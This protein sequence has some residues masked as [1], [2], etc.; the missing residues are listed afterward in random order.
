MGLER[1]SPDCDKRSKSISIILLSHI[2][3][4]TSLGIKGIEREVVAL[5]ITLSDLL[6][7]FLFPIPTT[8][9]SGICSGSLSSKRRNASPR[10]N[11]NDSN[12]LEVETATWPCWAPKATESTGKQGIY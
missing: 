6:V 12:E 10:E 8:L 3:R 4:F 7:Q 9:G 2:A 5:I 11:N 1:G